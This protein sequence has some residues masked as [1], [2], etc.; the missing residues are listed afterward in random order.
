MFNISRWAT[1]L[2]K[3]LFDIWKHLLCSLHDLETIHEI[4]HC[5]LSLFKLRTLSLNKSLLL[6][7]FSLNLFKEQVECLLLLCTDVLKLVQEAINVLWWVYLDSVLLA[8]LMQKVE[9]SLRVFA[10]FDL[11]SVWQVVR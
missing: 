3:S 8:L 11:C 4:G 9:E 7:N 1:C 6:G 2:L 10:C 5:L